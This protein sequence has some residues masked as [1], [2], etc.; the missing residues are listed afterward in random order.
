MSD[1]NYANHA[2]RPVPTVIGFAC[3]IVAVVGFTAMGR[4]YPW[5]PKMAWAGVLFCL[6]VL[7]SIGRTYTTKLQDR[8]ILLEERLRASALLTPDQQRRFSQLSAKQ[9]AALR[10]ASDAEFATLF[11]QAVSGNMKPDAI[12]RAVRDWRP[13]PHRT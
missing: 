13:D 6:L 10:F 8:V 5:G 11:E 7:L 9:V 12:K 2:H 4:G 3:W 1:Q